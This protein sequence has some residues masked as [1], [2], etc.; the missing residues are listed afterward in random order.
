[1][2]TDLYRGMKQTEVRLCDRYI[3]DHPPKFRKND[4]VMHPN[5]AGKVKAVV[6]DPLPSQYKYFI[7]GGGYFPEH[8]L[9]LVARHV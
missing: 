4:I 2:S 8:R 6:F 1:M 3:D 7:A 9:G 5:G